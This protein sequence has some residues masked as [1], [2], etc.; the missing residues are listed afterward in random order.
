MHVQPCRLSCDL[1]QVE[2]SRAA[3]YA[4][5]DPPLQQAR[6]KKAASKSEAWIL[7]GVKDSSSVV[8]CC[9]DAVNI[10]HVSLP[11]AMTGVCEVLD[12]ERE[13]SRSSGAGS[14]IP[15]QVLGDVSCRDNLIIFSEEDSGGRTKEAVERF[16]EKE[17]LLPPE[18]TPERESISRISG[19]EPEHGIRVALI[20]D[21]LGCLGQV[22]Q[23]ADG[24][25]ENQAGEYARPIL[26]EEGSKR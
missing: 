26:S 7:I 16:G 12:F 14:S 6:S 11:F 23:K 10:F 19:D 3:P 2:G 1:V 9:N 22:E 15:G 24:F 18:A 5:D 17:A 13:G 8:S 25:D 4:N 21:A 20:E